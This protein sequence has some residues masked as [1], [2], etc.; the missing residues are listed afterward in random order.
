MLFSLLDRKLEV[1]W[2][3]HVVGIYLDFKE[4]QQQGVI[5]PVM[6]MLTDSYYGQSFILD[7]L[8]RM[9]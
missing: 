5:V 1:E 2:L 8:N 6:P 4:I 9:G 7:I 3:G